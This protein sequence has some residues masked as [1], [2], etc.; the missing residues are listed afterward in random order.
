MYIFFVFFVFIFFV[1][2]VVVVVVVL[3]IWV[4]SWSFQ[5]IIFQFVNF[6]KSFQKI[7]KLKKYISSFEKKSSSRK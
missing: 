5:R 2:V 6:S 1:V 7:L 4:C 3:V